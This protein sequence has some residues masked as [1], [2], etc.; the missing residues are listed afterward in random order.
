MKNLLFLT[1][2]VVYR[3]IDRGYLMNI[4]QNT[5]LIVTTYNNPAFLKLSIISILKQTILPAEIVI[6][7][8]GSTDETYQ[9]I[10]ELKKISAIPIIHVWQPDKGF[11][12]GTIRNIAIAA[13]QKEYI[14]QIDGDIVAD[15]N[16][17][18]D[19]L[20]HKKNNT[21]LQGSRVFISPDKTKQMILCNDTSLSFFSDGLKRRENAIRSKF[22]STY[23]STRYRNRY[24]HY[25][26]RGCNMSFFRQDFIRVNG[27]NDSFNGWGHEDSELTLR[28]LNAGCQKDYIKFH[29]VAYHLYHKELSRAMEPEN[30]TIMD[31]QVKLNS[32]WCEY[33]VDQYLHTYL[34]YI[35]V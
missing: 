15:K 6:A 28:M 14:I 16:F 2:F 9:T 20:L 31:Q 27:Y 32:K 10:L 29:C 23:L 34:N 33:G 22:I 26:A 35:K 1:T 11:R 19:H 25:Y 12:A 13:T 4:D 17:I 18:A 8:D 30:K 5:S 24:P 3:L 7:D 21:L